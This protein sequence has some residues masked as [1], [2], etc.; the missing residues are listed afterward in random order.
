MS[1]RKRVCTNGDGSKGESWV[2]AYS[3]QARQA[4]HQELRAQARGRQ[5]PEGIQAGQ[6][7]NSEDL[8]ERLVNRAGA[9][10]RRTRAKAL[11]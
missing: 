11:D 6:A 9:R 5:L 7:A 8:A 2:V 4:P 3:D 10:P 1:I